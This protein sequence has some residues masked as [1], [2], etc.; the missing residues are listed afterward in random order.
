ASAGEVGQPAVTG[1]AEARGWMR[2][3]A[4]AFGRAL[5]DE[6]PP[7]GALRAA[8]A[9]ARLSALL[10]YRYWDEERRLFVQ[11][12][13]LFGTAPKKDAPPAISCGWILETLPLIGGDETLARILSELFNE[14]APAGAK[15]QVIS[16]T[17]PKIGDLIDP[18]AR[19][20]ISAGPLYEELARH[21]RE[22][23]RK[24]ASQSLSAGAPFYLRDFR[25]FVTCEVAGDLESP[26][27]EHLIEAREKFV[28]G[29]QS[30]GSAAAALGPGQLVSIL[31]DIL[32]PNSRINRTP[33]RYDPDAPLN[34]QLVRSDTTFSVYRDRVSAQTWAVA[35]PLESEPWELDLAGRNERFEYR[36]F[37]VAQYPDVCSQGLI[38]RTIG[39]L[40]NDQLRHVGS[41]LACLTLA[42][43]SIEKTKA[44]TD[45]KRLRTDQAAGN[46]LSRFFPEVRKAAEDWT[47]VAEEVADGACLAGLGYFVVSI[48]PAA[49]AERAER[50][51]RAVYRAARF[52]LRRDDDVHLPTLL[53]CLPLSLGGGLDEDL[54]RQGRMRRMPTTAASR[55]APLQG[56]FLGSD[57]PHLV[58][59]GRRGQP[60]AWS[61]FANRDGNHNV[62][63]VGSSGSGKSVLMQEIAGA[64]R[65]SGAEVMVIDDGFSFMSSC[66]LQGGAFVRFALGSGLC[67]NP[68]SLIDADAA[69]DDEEY[70]A[71]SCKLIKLLVELAARQDRRATAE[72]SGVIEKAVNA[73][74]NDLG[75]AGSIDAV[76]HWMRQNEGERGR[77]LALSLAAYVADGAYG[78]FFNGPAT[79]EIDNPLTV[80]EMSDLETKKDLRAVV[81]L[82]VLFLVRQRM[83]KGGRG[84]RK[85]L[86]VDEAWQLLADGATGEF[87]EGAARR[88]RKEGGALITGTQSLNDFYKTTGARACIENSDW[89]IMLRLMPESLEQLR[90]DAR[91]S[92]DE[93]TMQLLKSLKVSEGEYSEL[94]ISGPH[95]KF[96]GRLCLDPY[97]AVVYSSRP[98]VFTAVQTLVASGHSLPEA[99]R[100]VAFRE[101]A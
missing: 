8:Y 67:L 86:I 5:W 95:G 11:E 68:F 41:T 19:T 73:V 14:A 54:A 29:F 58:L 83:K 37:S 25:I 50:T 90:G 39:D 52:T 88:W 78:E 82:A 74:W 36:G 94:L 30:L 81:V 31:T 93:P 34:E 84:V 18:W 77:D 47:M 6:A 44:V 97:S 17:S 23:F 27:V 49:E 75:R 79:L 3:K 66:Q 98:D 15:L 101:A 69:A 80:F 32:N 60:F 20:R 56:E 92:V 76:A 59:V 53:A 48:A 43:W 12:R 2:R 1:L 21:R 35:D 65:S 71:E 7:P 45:F 99:V 61:P 9:P 85:A 22:H 13:P 16:W 51:L 100:K 63:I 57:T 28:A 89:R 42:P 40:F 55:L 33:E 91:L 64:L 87:I 72:E 46:P 4:E 96:L 62:A 26:A 38:A 70:A 10:P 24:G